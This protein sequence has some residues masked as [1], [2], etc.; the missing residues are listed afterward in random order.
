MDTSGLVGDPIDTPIN[1]QDTTVNPLD[2][3][4]ATDPFSTFME[5]QLADPQVG[6]ADSSEGNFGSY[7]D[8][9]QTF[10]F[11]S[12]IF[13]YGFDLPTFD[14]T[15][16][17]IG[18]SANDIDVGELR[19]A[20]DF[21]LE[22]LGT[23]PLSNA[24]TESE[25]I[26]SYFD[27]ES[28]G[29]VP[30][31]ITDPAAAPVPP[32]PAYAAPLAPTRVPTKAPIKAPSKASTQAPTPIQPP[33]P[34]PAT[35]K[36]P[37][38]VASQPNPTTTA[39]PKKKRVSGINREAAREMKARDKAIR[40]AAAL[41]DAAVLK[42][43]SITPRVS[44]AP[45]TG[46]T[47]VTT[48]PS[49]MVTL[50]AGFTPS[51]PMPSPPKITLPADF[52]PSYPMPSPPKVTLPAGFTPSYPMPSPPKVTLPAG[53]TPS[54]AMPSPPKSPPKSTPPPVRQTSSTSIDIDSTNMREKTPTTSVSHFKQLMDSHKVYSDT[55]A[56]HPSVHSGGITKDESTR[57]FLRLT[58]R[59]VIIPEGQ[60]SVEAFTRGHWPRVNRPVYVYKPATSSYPNDITSGVPHEYGLSMNS[61]VNV[62]L[63]IAWV[64]EP[65]M[66][67]PHPQGLHPQ[68][69]RTSNG[70]PELGVNGEPLRDLKILPRYISSAVEGWRMHYWLAL[71][72]RI[73]YTDILARMHFK[74]TS[75]GGEG[76]LADG[77]TKVIRNLKSRVDQFRRQSGILAPLSEPFDPDTY[78]VT[79][80]DVVAVQR[81]TMVQLEYG[82][83]WTVDEQS[84]I[85]YPPKPENGEA[86]NQERHLLPMKAGLSPRVQ[87]ILEVCEPK[88]PAAMK[89]GISAVDGAA[90]QEE[91]LK[92]FKA[93]QG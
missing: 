48:V 57:R 33:K 41:R 82:T 29:Y 32:A 61:S 86:W 77:S 55:A 49:P 27:P 10:D 7:G 47:T 39:A 85:M 9:V 30:A 52:T 6:Q 54:Y 18:D 12:D 87:K 90:R 63:P 65:R 84:G 71:D 73:T 69:L 16:F 14:N 91:A 58:G 80:A 67:L 40:E 53:F 76:P 5:N 66:V 42:A 50:P 3:I 21:N 24:T 89:R 19:A 2:L 88:R 46:Y 64:D 45:Q 22:C 4:L 28:L 20:S 36:Q 1:S 51:Y 35:E 60:D 25:I 62:P 17:G 78:E 34:T 93:K 79:G 38:K 37:P 81:L 13:D 44:P 72:K 74:C 26:G 43:K 15:E 70:T 75:T 56:M 92:K 59:Q 23:S 8:D 11:T 31:W 68:P 83:W